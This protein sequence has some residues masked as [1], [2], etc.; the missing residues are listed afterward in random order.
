M[1]DDSFTIRM[2]VLRNSAS[3]FSTK[4][5]MLKDECLQPDLFPD[6]CIWEDL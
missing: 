5:V 3:A 1:H 2:L 6:V 4:L